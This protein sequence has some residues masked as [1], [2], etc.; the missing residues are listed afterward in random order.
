MQTTQAGID[1]AK[2]V[3]E[4]ALSETPGTVRE[5]HRLSRAR[6]RRFFAT[7]ETTTV[8]MEACGSAHYWGRELQAMGHEV[9]LLHPGDVARYRDGNKTDRAD[10]KAVLEAARNTAIDPVPVKT[11]EQQAIAALHRMRQGYLQT[12]TARINAVRGHM[13]EF[14]IV[15]PVGA[16]HVVTRAESALDTAELPDVLRHAL[17]DLLA[18]IEELHAKAERLRCELERLARTMPEADLLLSVPG[19]GVLTATA[20]VAFVGDLGRFRSDR[21]LAAYLGL[22]PRE[23]SSGHNRRL[24]RI[25]KRGNSYVRMLLIHGARSALRA[26][27]MTDAPDDLRTWALSIARRRGFNVAAVALANK[28][29]RVCWRVCHDQRPFE[30]REAA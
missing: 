2:A 25:T 15:L 14:G 3:F 26:G 21:D 1:I 27:S 18:E 24:G 17:I 13:R 28:L 12:R 23:H 29:A 4:V 20:L 10:A 7:R 11:Q 22:T 5:R 9:R 19:I 30:R 6:F 16:R 8:L